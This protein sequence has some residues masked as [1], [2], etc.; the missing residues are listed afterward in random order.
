MSGHT[1]A[2]QEQQFLRDVRENKKHFKGGRISQLYL[3]KR[4][5]RENH[6]TSYEINHGSNFGSEDESSGAYISRLTG[7][8]IG[9]LIDL[10]SSSSKQSYSSS[11]INN[12]PAIYGTP[13][14]KFVSQ[15]I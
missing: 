13:V 4:N 1:I 3:H 10:S 6:G 12:P 9:S 14:E 8:I 5:R 11:S 7:K 2:E 15:T